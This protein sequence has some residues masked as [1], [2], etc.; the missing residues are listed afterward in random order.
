MVKMKSINVGWLTLLTLVSCAPTRFAVYAS[1]TRHHRDL[2]GNYYDYERTLAHAYL[3]NDAQTATLVQ[4]LGR[5]MD[6]T[7]G[8]SALLVCLDART[9]GEVWRTVSLEGSTVSI[10]LARA[11]YEK[12]GIRDSELPP[13]DVEH[14]RDVGPGFRWERS[15]IDCDTSCG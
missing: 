8:T 7:E 15:L 11:A 3:A 12:A 5:R 2:Y 9:D 4:S 13:L 1:R 10:E 14:F 6:Y